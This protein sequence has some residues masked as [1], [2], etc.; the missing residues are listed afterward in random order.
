MPGTVNKCLFSAQ[1][2]VADP[3]S[4]AGKPSQSKLKKQQFVII[5]YTSFVSSLKES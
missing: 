3:N 2:C 5:I 1:V 4:M